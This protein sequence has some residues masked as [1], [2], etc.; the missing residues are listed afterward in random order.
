MKTAKL[1]IDFYITSEDVILK[2]GTVLKFDTVYSAAEGYNLTK[3]F[4]ERNPDIFE[5]EEIVEVKAPK[6]YSHT[7]TYDDL[8]E[9]SVTEIK[10]NKFKVIVE[11]T[12]N[13]I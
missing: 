6:G 9:Y 10:P 5:V 4:V 2:K 3:N 13:T 7:G 1:K 8:G 11:F 12:K